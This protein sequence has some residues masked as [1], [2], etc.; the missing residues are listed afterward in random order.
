MFTDGKTLESELIF[1]ATK[2]DWSATN[3]VGVC[4]AKCKE[5]YPEVCMDVTEMNDYFAPAR[6]PG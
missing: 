6:T 2:A 3:M 4:Q 5:V 1:S